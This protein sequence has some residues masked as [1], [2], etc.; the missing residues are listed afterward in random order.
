VTS[1]YLDA[2]AAA[3]SFDPALARRVRAEAAD[4]LQQAMAADGSHDRAAAERRAIAAFGDI[5]AIAAPFVVI[6]LARRI[7]KLRVALILAVAAIFLAM[8]GRV[9]WYV[10]TGW[11]AGHD[12][13]PATRIIAAIDRCAFWSSVV[14]AIGAFA[15]LAVRPVAPAVHRGLRQEAR[16]A[17]S[18]GMAAIAPLALAVTSDGALTWLQLTGAELSAGSLVP[19]ATMAI[20]IACIAIVSLEAASFSY[21]S[22]PA[23]R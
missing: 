15:Y 17:L 18:L 3:L 14:V 2:L 8:K 22:F 10:V 6:S 12:A 20:E 21:R 19:I 11:N 7:A 13:S 16:R 4:H 5:E 23:P 9:T 1:D